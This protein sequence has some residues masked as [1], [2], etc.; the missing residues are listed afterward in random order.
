MEVLSVCRVSIDQYSM[1][2]VILFSW[3][4]EGVM[5]IV[6]GIS[7]GICDH[8]QGMWDEYAIGVTLMS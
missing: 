8:I 5:T 4:V 7:F 1:I 2:L 6:I 3:G